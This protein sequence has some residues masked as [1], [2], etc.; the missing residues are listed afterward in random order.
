[1]SC[2]KKNRKILVRATGKSF[3]YF[4]HVGEQ[5]CVYNSISKTR[6]LKH[7]KIENKTRLWFSWLYP[8]I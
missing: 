4:V 5:N 8:N 2:Q 3:A 1:M 7:I 6:L